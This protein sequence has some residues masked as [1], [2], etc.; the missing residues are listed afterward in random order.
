LR[1]IKKLISVGNSKAVILPS[2]MV[3][4]YGLEKVFIEDTNDGILIRSASHNS[5]LHVAIEKLRKH[6]DSLYKRMESQANNI[7]TV[8]YYAKDANNFSEAGLDI[9]DE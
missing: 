8:K 2:E 6:K 3:K 5:N 1:M 9:L 7:N 4:K